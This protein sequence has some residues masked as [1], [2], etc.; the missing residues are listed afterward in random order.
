MGNHQALPECVARWECGILR[1]LHGWY[2]KINRASIGCDSLLIAQYS[3]VLLLVGVALSLLALRH[4]KRQ[5]DQSRRAQYYI[6][7][8]E[9]ARS[10]GRWAIVSAVVM[11]LTIGVA[12]TASQAPTAPATEPT[13]RPTAAVPTL[14][15]V[16]TRT[17]TATRTPVPTVTAPPTLTPTATPAPDVPAVLL[18]P[19]PGAAEPDAAATFEFLTLA[20]RVGE[21]LSPLDPGLQFPTG[22]SRVYVFF[23]ASGVNN[24]ARWGIFCYRGET[25]VDLFVGL[26]EDGPN[27]QTSRA[28]CGL[29]GAAGAYLLRA[30]LGTS[31]AF[32]VQ[33]SLAGAPAPTATP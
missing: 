26:W 10:A 29:D 23:R 18:T 31:L 6:L 9:A 24:G 13:I 14:G 30:Y 33:Y 32:Q 4:T 25:I 3:T 16:P 12:V 1:A 21:N 11:A 22:T 28:F 27:P 20:S 15:P 8:E 17:P 7:R 2:R 5:F 19:V